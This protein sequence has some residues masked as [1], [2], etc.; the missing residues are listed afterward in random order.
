MGRLIK[1]NIL[2]LGENYDTRK[3]DRGVHA[4]GYVIELLHI[5]R[6]KTSSAGNA[7]SHCCHRFGNLGRVGSR[8]GKYLSLYRIGCYN[9]S[10]SEIRYL[11]IDS[12]VCR[13]L[14]QARTSVI[15]V[16]LLIIVVVIA[17]KNVLIVTVGNNDKPILRVGIGVLGVYKLFDGFFDRIEGGITVGFLTILDLID[18]ILNTAG[19]KIFFLSDLRIIQ[20]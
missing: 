10:D 4:E 5:G 11:Q 19:G 8:F 6:V 9:L 20:I 17:V 7:V 2:T 13:Q 16:L 1:R 14:E 18:R 15:D 3:R 12:F